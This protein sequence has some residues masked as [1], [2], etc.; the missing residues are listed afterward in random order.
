MDRQSDRGA[1]PEGN[2]GNGTLGREVTIWDSRVG[3]GKTRQD[4]ARHSLRDYVSSDGSDEIPG[5]CEA[6]PAR[7]QEAD[8]NCRCKRTEGPRAVSGAPCWT[9]GTRHRSR[10]ASA[11]PMCESNVSAGSA[12]LGM[13]PCA[14]A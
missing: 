2:T 7:S 3:N 5:S 14:I 10:C 12:V 11:A 6:V 13:A 4:L 9:S 8:G 1:V